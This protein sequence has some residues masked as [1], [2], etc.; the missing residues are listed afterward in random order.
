METNENELTF[1]GALSELEGIVRELE[2]G[3]LELEDSL[4]RYERGVKLIRVL[5]E[6]LETAEQKVTTLLGDIEPETGREEL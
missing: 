5:Q 3:Q 4:L 2:G 6:K 1:S